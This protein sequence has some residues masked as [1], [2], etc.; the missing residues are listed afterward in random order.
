M[1]NRQQLL[2][3]FWNYFDTPQGRCDLQAKSGLNENWNNAKVILDI[4]VVS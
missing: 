1:Q 3:L 2:V 4:I